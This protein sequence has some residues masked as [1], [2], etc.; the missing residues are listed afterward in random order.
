VNKA[1]L[2]HSEQNHTCITA[3]ARYDLYCKRSSGHQKETIPLPPRRS[4]SHQLRKRSEIKNTNKKKASFPPF[5]FLPRPRSFMT[6]GSAEDAWWRHR[7]CGSSTV[8]HLPRPHVLPCLALHGD[9]G[10]RCLLWPQSLVCFR[11]PTED[12]PL[13][14]AAAVVTSSAMV[15]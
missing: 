2:K 6:Y 3:S 5:I 9:L 11:V 15:T 13:S 4:F 14:H 10:R 8:G 12:T 1:L 7:S